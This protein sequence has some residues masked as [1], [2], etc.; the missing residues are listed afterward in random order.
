MND[1]EFVAP[2][3][4]GICCVAIWLVLFYKIAFRPSTARN[5]A[6]PFTVPRTDAF[7]QGLTIRQ[8][9]DSDYPACLVIYE[10]NSE[11]LPPMPELFLQTIEEHPAGFLVAVLHGKIVACGGVTMLPEKGY[12]LL[13]MGLVHRAHHRQKIGTLML[14]VRLALVEDGAAVATL[15]T[16]AK[17]HSFYESFGFCRNSKS[18]KRYLGDHSHFGMSRFLPKYPG[19]PIR[20]YLRKTGVTFAFDLD[21]SDFTISHQ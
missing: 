9:H 19:N 16:T 14:L 2:L 21:E 12:A 10:S 13:W 3:L 18:E 4:L 7:P 15:E 1:S 11:F 5:R 17:T 20:Q 6:K 8:Y